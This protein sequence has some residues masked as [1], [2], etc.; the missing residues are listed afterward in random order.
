M[1]RQLGIISLIA[2]FVIFCVPGLASA[3]V[4]DEA[5]VSNSVQDI[6]LMGN[7]VA[8]RAP[9]TDPEGHAL[10][11]QWRIVSDPTG[12]ARFAGS[13]ANAFATVEFPW[14]SPTGNPIGSSIILE[15]TVNHADIQLHGDVSL[16]RRFE[17]V[18]ARVNQPPEPELVVDPVS[19]PTNRISEGEGVSFTSD[20]SVDPDNSGMRHEWWAWITGGSFLQPLVFYGTEGNSSGFTIPRLASP[21]ATVGVTLVLIDGL[22][23]VREQTTVY[24]KKRDETTRTRQPRPPIRYRIGSRSVFRDATPPTR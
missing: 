16:S 3:P 4:W 12:K 2:F 14:V 5:T 6:V 22:H 21:T 11:F 7:P 9:A 15:V 19:S 1:P 10:S 20:S 13:P 8:F 23:Q 24:L 17:A 18:I